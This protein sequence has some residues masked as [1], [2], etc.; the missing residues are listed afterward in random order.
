MQL[1]DA[2]EWILVITA[3]LTMLSIAGGVISFAFATF[4]TLKEY[5]LKLDAEKRTS[6]SQKAETDVRLVQ[7]FSEI[8]NTANGRAG[9]VV[10]EK[11]IEELFKRNVFKEEDFSDLIALNKRIREF[12][13]IYLPVGSARKI[14][15]PTC[16]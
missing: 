1:S 3:G 11:A 7:A 13:V 2:K 9:Y 8:M 14:A 10:S 6:A 4:F 5:R 16:A 12:P 15:L